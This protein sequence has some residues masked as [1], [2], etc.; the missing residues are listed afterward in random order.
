MTIQNAQ[1]LNN[2]IGSMTRPPIVVVLGHVDHGKSTLIETIREDF[3]ITSKES[4]GITQHIG[5]YEAEYQG[6]K[7]TFIDTPGHEVF[8]AIRSRGAKVADIAIL[9][10]AA[11]EGVK[12][13]TKEAIEQIKKAGLPMIV[14][15][16]K[17]D[18]PEANPQRIKQELA[19]QEVLV[20][21][22]GGK[23]PVIE[24]SALTKQGIKDLLEM[25][26]LVAEMG[27]FKAQVDKPGEGV[28]IETYLDNKRGSAATILV[29]DGVVRTG[30]FIATKST[31]GRVR[32]LENFQGKAVP[33]TF[34]SQPAT[35]IGFEDC[36][37]LGEEFRVFPN[38]ESS[39][40][41]ATGIPKK[42][43][44]SRVL[45]ANSEKKILNVIL[46]ADVAGSLEALEHIFESLPQDQV[47]M[48]VVKAEVGEIGEDD[49]KLAKGARASILGFRTKANPAAANLA[50]QTKIKIETFHV[51]YELVQ[52]T[53]EFMEKMVQEQPTREEK[54]S[55][56]VL[57]VFLS[58]KE[59]QIIGGRVFQGEATKG[60]K[61]EVVRNEELVEKGRILNLQKNKKDAVSVPKG[62]ECGLL[63]EGTIRIQ[64]GDVL[65]FYTETSP[66]K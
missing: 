25:I 53:R 66:K 14:A 56:R 52:K 27:T 23:T 36:P 57:A 37:Q 50:D 65:K 3:Q 15:I 10:V 58:D 54:G 21:S 43:R 40:L 63:Y 26:L 44:G 17:I 11:D 42:E 47:L 19:Q 28:I 55:L 45:E 48:R 60:S 31:R 29:R 2:Q 7:I 4:G 46:K 12:L 35:M 64:E 13:Q 20:E 8:S 49:V 18:K 32:I 22:F 6:K 16:N 9:V 5:A 1:Q 51:I 24:T 34:P 39:A 41:F 38:Q 59:R 30:D 33:Q 62:E 61:V